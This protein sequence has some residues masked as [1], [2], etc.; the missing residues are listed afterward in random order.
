MLNIGSEE[1]RFMQRQGY[2]ATRDRNSIRVCARFALAGLFAFT[3][4]QIEGCAS[5]P[6]SAKAESFALP[7]ND[8]DPR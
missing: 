1:L 8:A 3:M 5:L 7:A 6:P 4:A 2:A